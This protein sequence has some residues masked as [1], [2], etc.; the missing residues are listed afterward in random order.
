MKANARADKRRMIDDIAEEAESAA[1]G[2]N[3]SDLYRLVKKTVQAKRNTVTA[4]RVKLGVLLMNKD[5]ILSRWKEH[6]DE[7]LNIDYVRS[8]MPDG[9]GAV[10]AE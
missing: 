1:Q 2:N 6:F 9:N 7:V 10:S 8:N 4:I 5:E 3:I